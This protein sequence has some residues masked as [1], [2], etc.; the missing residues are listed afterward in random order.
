MLDP[1][2]RALFSDALRPPS[3]HTVDLALGTTFTLSLRMLFLPP[4][5][6]AAHDRET[7]LPSGDDETKPDTLA[8]LESIRRYADRTTLYCHAGGI[9]PLAEYPRL[10]TFAEDSLVQV[11]P[12][13]PGHL[14]HPKLWALRF[15]CDGSLI[16]RLLISSRNLTD[17]RSWDT[18]LVL[19][20]DT[21]GDGIDGTPAADFVRS[22]PSLA[23][24]HIAPGRADQAADLARTLTNARFKPPDPFTAGTL[25]PLGLNATN[26]WPM[27]AKT[28]RALVI[29]PFLDAQAA[30]RAQARARPVF[31]SRAET[32]DRVGGR[33]FSHADVRVLSPHAEA[34]FAEPSPG[35]PDRPSEVRSG[36][37]AKVIVWDQGPT[38]HVF[39]GSANVTTAAYSGNVE[40]G[41]LLTGPRRTC[42]VEA[43]LPTDQQTR[44][45]VAFGH[46]LEPH[47]ITDLEP[48]PDPVFDA[49]RDITRFHEEILRAGPALVVQPQEDGRFTVTLSFASPL[50][51]GP[52]TTRVRL[53]SRSRVERLPLNEGRWA[54]VPL[55]ELT[56]Y[57][58]LVTRAPIPDREDPLELTCI[59]KAELIGAPDS[60]SAEVLRSYLGSEE[61]IVRY[62]RFLLDEVDSGLAWDELDPLGPG[63]PAFAGPQRFEDLA[64]LEPL[65]K[66]AAEGSEALDRVQALLRDL[67]VDRD[68]SGA[69]PADF[70]DLWEAVWSAARGGG[71]P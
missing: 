13:T 38:G 7:E 46:I 55:L 35:N 58:E 67:E 57:L 49:E 23:L 14:F 17:D 40:F 20:E 33:A 5:A 41:V 4:L 19:D 25:W 56:P 70:L 50:P 16:H 10:L 2:T 52:G 63:E 15:K 44:D 45:R 6:M 11:V 27:P 36:L 1:T 54:G 42:G 21:S 28:D 64:I 9:G 12:R 69:V 30:H 61:A 47:T 26:G 68:G 39:T 37:H 60:R 22:L 51:V 66:A 31:V 53:I 62:L 48:K 32:Y 65:L 71:R 43:M 29:S 18:L 59:L 34:E 8:L 24:G 3:G